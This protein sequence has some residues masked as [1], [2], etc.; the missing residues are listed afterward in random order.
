MAEIVWTGEA[1]RC[2][3]DIYNYISGDSPS[4]AHKVVCNPSLYVRHNYWHYCASCAPK[5]KV[6]VVGL[7]YFDEVVVQV[8]CPKLR[9][10]GYHDRSGK[11]D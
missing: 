3:E 6:F 7:P 11:P 8:D 4:A 9:D 1:T 2:L 5:V 10:W